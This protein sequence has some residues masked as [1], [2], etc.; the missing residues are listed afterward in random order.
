MS[1]ASV[2]VITLNWNRCQDTLECLASLRQLTYQPNK[3]FVLDQGSVDNSVAEIRRQF[4]EATVIE[5]GQNLGFARGMNLGIRHALAAGA[6]HLLL[7]N[8]DTLVAPAMLTRMMGCLAPDVALVAPTIFYVDPPD[9]IW[10]AGGGIHPVL[11]EM[12]GN[13]GRNGP[14][15][16]HPVERPFLCACALLAPRQVFE[17]VGYFDERFFMYYEDLDFCL[18]ARRLG[19][20]LLLAPSAHLWHKVSQSSEGADSPQERYLMARSSGIYFR[21]H[22]HGWRIPLILGYRFLSALR[23]TGRLLWRRR[24]RALGA[25]WRGLR[26]GWLQPTPAT[27]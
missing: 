4:P 16:A 13:H 8:N 26:D 11:L 7:L 9:Q 21:K 20:R 2:H 12:S 3:I 22:M 19:L 14:L 6:T 18:R 23:C 17:T 5:V 25:Y 27:L 1:Q 24:W 15:P 10:S